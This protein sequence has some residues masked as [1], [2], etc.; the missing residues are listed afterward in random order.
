VE[1][2]DQELA[3][4]SQ[5]TIVYVVGSDLEN[6]LLRFGPLPL[7][8]EIPEFECDVA[9]RMSILAQQVTGNDANGNKIWSGQSID[10]DGEATPGQG[11]EIGI[12]AARE[13]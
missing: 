8:A 1:S 11:T 10:G 12:R 6:R 4:A 2:F 3:N 5:L 7:I 13:D 9:P